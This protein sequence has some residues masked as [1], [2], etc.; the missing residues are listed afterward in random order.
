MCWYLD[1]CTPGLNCVW[2]YWI[3]KIIKLILW[4]FYLFFLLQ[5]YSIFTYPVSIFIN[6]FYIFQDT[7]LGLVK[8]CLSFLY[9]KNIQRL[10][11]VSKC[12]W[13]FIFFCCFLSDVLGLIMFSYVS[14]YFQTF[15]T[16]SLTDMANRVQ[17]TGPAEAEFYI[18]K[19]VISFYVIV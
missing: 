10:T 9:K 11:K 13:L 5:P 4:K 6:N 7:N 14:F 18:L 1:F 15:L 8:Q 12:T 3:I 17:F 2:F 16:L 19:M